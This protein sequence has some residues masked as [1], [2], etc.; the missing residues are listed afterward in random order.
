MTLA[1]P[2]ANSIQQTLYR[3]DATP[4][5]AP[6]REFFADEAQPFER[7]QSP[8]THALGGPQTPAP[9]A[10]ATPAH[11]SKQP[12]CPTAPAQAQGSPGGLLKIPRAHPRTRRQQVRLLRLQRCWLATHDPTLSF[13]LVRGAVSLVGNQ[14]RPGGEWSTKTFARSAACS[15]DEHP[16]VGDIVF[17]RTGMLPFIPGCVISTIKQHHLSSGLKIPI[18]AACRSP[19]NGVVLGWRLVQFRQR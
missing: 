16:A 15:S 10:P 1:I 19:H 5:P 4:T 13:V 9:P 6:S 17:P 3:T 11:M 18:A 14:A 7:R 2:S 12:L 8:Q